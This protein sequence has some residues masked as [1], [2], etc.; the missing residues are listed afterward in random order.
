MS[1]E[2]VKITKCDYCGVDL[3]NKKDYINIYASENNWLHFVRMVNGIDKKDIS[4]Y[5][6]DFC[7]TTCMSNWINE[8]LF[9]LEDEQE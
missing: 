3:K 9:V 7:D 6:L 1:T 2:K 8:N 4:F 5:E